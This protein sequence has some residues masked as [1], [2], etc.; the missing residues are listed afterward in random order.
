MLGSFQLAGPNFQFENTT[1]NFGFVRQGDI[2]TYDYTFKNTGTETLVIYDAKVECHCTE[3]RTSDSVLP[4]KTGVIHL[5]F[6]SKSA[7]GRQVRTIELSSNATEKPFT[8]VFK[9]FVR[10]KKS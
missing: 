10:R 6:D 1:H 4:G 7:M 3:V 9:C 8:L 2:L 5:K